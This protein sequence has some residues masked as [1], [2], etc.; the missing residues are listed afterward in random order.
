MAFPPLAD[1][2]KEALGTLEQGLVRLSEQ[3]PG[4]QPGRRPVHVLYGGAH[5]FQPGTLAKIRDLA[6]AALDTYAPD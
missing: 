5:L 4:L 1:A 6:R 2:L 3:R